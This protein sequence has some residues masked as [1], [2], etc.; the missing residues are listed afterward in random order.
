M[1][2][3]T[4]IIYTDGGCSP[5]PGLGG[6]SAVLISPGHNNF[7]KELSGAEPDSTNNRMELTAAIMALRSLKRSCKVE[8]HTD[9]HYLKKAFTDNWLKKW[10]ANGWKNANKKSV[11]N[12]DLWKELLELD[13]KHEI[14]WKWVK[15][16][17]D[18]EFN[19]RCDTLVAE[20]RNNYT[21]K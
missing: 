7:N 18:N 13:T 9:S 20:A 5:N 11:A 12:V 1:E 8:L 17:S 10:L 19:T 15:G 3:D 4:V 21:S 14:K 6:W 2:K 16:H